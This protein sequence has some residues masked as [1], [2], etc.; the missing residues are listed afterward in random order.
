[1]YSGQAFG[2]GLGGWLISHDMMSHLHWYGFAVMLLAMALSQWS[3][4]NK[5]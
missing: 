2:A 3:R 5:A 1:M 4:T